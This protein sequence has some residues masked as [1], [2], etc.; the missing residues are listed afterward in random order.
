MTMAPSSV[1]EAAPSPSPDVTAAMTAAAVSAADMPKLLA[2]P[3]LSPTVCG[4]LE[5]PE[6]SR[7]LLG[8]AAGVASN[9]EMPLTWLLGPTGTAVFLDTDKDPPAPFTRHRSTVGWWI[10]RDSR[11]VEPVSPGAVLRASTRSGL[12]T[13]WH[14]ERSRCLLDVVAARTVALDGPPVAVGYTVSDIVVELA[15]RRWSDLDEV[16]LVGFGREMHGLENVRYLPTLE[17]ATALLTGVDRFGDGG[18]RCLVIAPMPVDEA[19]RGALRRLLRLVEQTPFSGAVCCDTAVEAHCTWHLAAHRQTV[20]LDV[21]GRA[22]LSAIVSRERWAERV[23]NSL[24]V[25]FRP[26]AAP[27]GL[28]LGGRVGTSALMARPSREPAS[29]GVTVQVLGPVQIDG[30]AESLEGRPLLKELVVY[31]AFHPEGV[32]G[33]AC[34]TVLWPERRVPAQTLSNRLHEARRALGATVDGT[35]RLIRSGGRHLLSPDVRTDW[36]RF[37]ALTGADCGP[38]SW[39]QA[40]MLVRGRP[41]DGL[42]KGDWTVLEGL[43]AGI[44]AGVGDVAARLGGILLEEGDPVGA[45]WAARRGLTLTPWDERLYRLLMMAAD[46]AG[47]RGGVEAALR[48]LA[49]VLGWPGDPIEIVHP[50]TASLYRK[51]TEQP[52]L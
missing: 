31:L 25:A 8:L 26:V 12:V 4:H 46:A 9:G 14:D 47:N 29:D 33:E 28:S 48:S 11:L 3:V 37:A 17:D 7:A 30:T 10:D 50:D 22:G 5:E 52:E 39:R 21:S 18:A 41:F 38:A 24:R 16:L 44:E 51:L 43:S 15:S 6:W 2:S 45:E 40:L 27:L 1:A 20:R 42:A 19:H 34:A 13:L 49:Q 36:S 35:P 32:T 23:G